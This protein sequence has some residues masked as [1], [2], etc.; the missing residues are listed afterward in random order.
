MDIER[1]ADFGDLC[2]ESPVWDAVHGVLYWADCGGLRF[3]RYDARADR[4]ELLHGGLEI[5][6]FRRNRSGGFAIVNN[7][8]IWVWPGPGS[9]PQLIASDAGGQRCRMNDCAADARGRLLSG[10]WFYDPAGEYP[11]GCLM[12]VDPDGGVTVL[13]DGYCLSNGL[14]FSPDGRRLYVTDSARRVIYEYDYDP[15]SGAATNRRVRVT[16]P[17]D[18]GLPDGL[19]VDASGFLWSAQWYGGCV[20][21][22]DPDGK[23]ER[24]ISVPAKQVS[25]ITFGGGNLSTLF[26]TTAGQS[27]AMPIMP[28]G[29]DPRTGP[30]GG[31]LYRIETGIEGL[32]D[33]EADISL[34]RIR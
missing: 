29:Y 25:C 7:S 3:Y 21:R 8:G 15:S 23:P 28:P 32:A 24:R 26:I 9:D 10:S 4:A 27:E 33:S 22:Y 20:V 16:V 6:G 14:A 12:R 1:V 13:D 17:G 31:G 19:R 5:N 30:F 11:L 34:A 2:G 18:E